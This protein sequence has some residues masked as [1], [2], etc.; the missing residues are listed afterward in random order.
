MLQDW[1]TNRFYRGVVLYHMGR[2]EEAIDSVKGL[3]IPWAGQGP[4]ATEALAQ[5]ALG[6][7]EQAELALASLQQGGAHGF[8]V[9]LVQVGLGDAEAAFA[10]FDT[11]SSWTT[12]ADWPVLAA[13]YLFPGVLDGLREDPRYDRLLRNIDRAWGLVI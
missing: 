5:V 2:Y 4:L 1:P 8:L 9:G 6:N 3:S 10:S 13:R 11:I 12:D 7:R